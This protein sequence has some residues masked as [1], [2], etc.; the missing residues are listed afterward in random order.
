MFCATKTDAE[1]VPKHFHIITWFFPIFQR[2][3]I[4]VGYILHLKKTLFTVFSL[5]LRQDPIYYFDV[6]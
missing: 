3:W 6:L 2:Q 4:S 1:L 5:K